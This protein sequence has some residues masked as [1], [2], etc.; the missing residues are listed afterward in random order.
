MELTVEQLRNA[1]LGNM[2]EAQVANAVKSRR[3]VD[4][5]DG[6]ETQDQWHDVEDNTPSQ[7]EYDHSAVLS[8]NLAEAVQAGQ[9]SDRTAAATSVFSATAQMM[10]LDPDVATSYAM[11]AIETGDFSLIAKQGLR[12]S[13]SRDSYSVRL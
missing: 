9:I 10:G 6:Y 2:L 8:A 7:G 12:Q 4:V 11:D 3:A 13:C 5:G 1:G